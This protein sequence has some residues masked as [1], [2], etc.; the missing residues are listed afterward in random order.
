M[1][2]DRLA[3]E[4]IPIADG[5]MPVVIDGVQLEPRLQARFIGDRIK[6]RIWQA[7]RMAP[8]KWGELTDAETNVAAPPTAVII[9]ESSTEARAARQAASRK[10][11]A[12][13]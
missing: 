13:D 3:A 11:R 5:K 6:A 10:E 12:R 8:R 2:A 7:G 1:A 4:V 9:V